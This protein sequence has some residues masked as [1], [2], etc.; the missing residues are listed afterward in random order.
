MIS[1]KIAQREEMESSRGD[2][3]Y[4]LETVDRNTRDVIFAKVEGGNLNW[5]FM[6]VFFSVFV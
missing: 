2:K 6:V 3:R 1:H 5:V 4:R